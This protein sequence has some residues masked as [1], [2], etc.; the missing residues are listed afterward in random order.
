MHMYIHVC[1]FRDLAM[2]L[3]IDD[4]QRF[5]SIYLVIITAGCNSWFEALH[6]Y[7][8][9]PLTTTAQSTNIA[10]ISPSTSTN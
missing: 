10:A 1:M 5:I 8:Y 3:D 2:P 7:M 9:T 6:M 4:A